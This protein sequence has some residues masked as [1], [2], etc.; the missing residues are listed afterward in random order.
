LLIIKKYKVGEVYASNK[1]G[2]WYGATIRGEHQPV[3]IG[4]FS[5]IGDYTT[6]HT[7]T[8]MG[9]GVPS[10]VNIGKNVHIGN[11]CSL[12]SCIIDDDCVI[13][14]GSI[15][16][17]GSRLERGCV[18]Q[19]YSVIPPGRLIPA[20]QVWGGSPV[21][22]IKEVDEKTK[23]KNYEKS[24]TLIEHAMKHLENIALPLKLKE[25]D[26]LSYIGVPV[27]KE[28]YKMLCGPKV[29]EKAAQLPK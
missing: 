16:A 26:E 15:I 4:E 3:R 23:L 13:G 12:T 25:I 6:I 28:E 7:F 29:N 5:T 22:F 24:Y 9:I 11:N 18:L 2:I 20:G 17:E 8:S 19:P 21:K 14:Q 1:V 27:D 10:S